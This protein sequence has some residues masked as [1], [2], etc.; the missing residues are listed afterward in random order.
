M[1]INSHATINTPHYVHSFYWQ[2][3]NQVRYFTGHRHDIKVIAF[4]F[5]SNMFLN[6]YFMKEW[7]FMQHDVHFAQSASWTFEKTRFSLHLLVD[8]GVDSFTVL[9]TF[10]SVETAKIRFAK[11]QNWNRTE[12]LFARI[13]FTPKLPKQY[14][15]TN[16]R[17]LNISRQTFSI[18]RTR[19]DQN[20]QHSAW[21][22]TRDHCQPLLFF[23][24]NINQTTLS[25]AF[26]IIILFCQ[27]SSN[28]YLC[29]FPS[30]LA[31]FFSCFTNV[32][33]FCSCKVYIERFSSFRY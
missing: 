1:K 29:R 11:Q 17:K 19:L 13:A 4:A 8:R 14:S 24:E 7:G 33:N 26:N 5:C 16:K 21:P 2:L 28:C 9:K 15:Q 30:G 27:N 3:R 10:A 22:H 31:H 25:A 18:S 6:K 20:L 32:V 23:A 12:R